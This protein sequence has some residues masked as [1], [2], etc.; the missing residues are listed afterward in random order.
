MF[1]YL[2]KGTKALGTFPSSPFPADLISIDP[3]ET[4]PLSQISAI[5]CFLFLPFIIPIIYHIC[6]LSFLSF[7]IPAIH[8]SYHSSYLPFTIST[9]RHTSI[10]TIFLPQKYASIYM[11][12]QIAI[13]VVPTKLP[14][15]T[16]IKSGE[17][18][19]I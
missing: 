18:S 10:L 6:H 9:I 3:P 14:Y 11:P 8:R 4:H 16:P 7:I 17:V 13:I 19:L 12:K 5:L 2:K 1:F 15:I